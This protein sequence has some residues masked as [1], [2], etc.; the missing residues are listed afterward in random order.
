M[1]IIPRFGYRVDLGFK[2]ERGVRRATL[3]DA[4]FVARE[5]GVVAI[6]DGMGGPGHGELAAQAAL[7]EVDKAMRAETTLGLAE[8]YLQHPDL[9]SRRLVLRRLTRIV[10]RAH[11]RVRELGQSF[12]T[13]QEIGTTV[14]VLWLLREEAFLAHVGDGRAYAI[15]PTAVM[16]LTEDHSVPCEV[17]RAPDPA[18]TRGFALSRLGNAV[19]IGERCSVDTLL[20]DLSQ[21]DKLLLLTDGVWNTV[22]DEAELKALLGGKSAGEAAEALVRHAQKSSF[23]DCTAMVVQIGERFVGHKT[24][25]TGAISRDIEPLAESA[26]LVGLPWPRILQ[27]LQIAVHVEFE[28]GQMLSSRVANDR[29]CY[30]ILAGVVRDRHAKC[31][32]QGA[33]LYAESLVGC[34]S[35]GPTCQCVEAARALRIRRDD[36]R[37]VCAADPTLALEL[38]QRLAAHLGGMLTQ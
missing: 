30:I 22:G 28:A 9:E 36:Y 29:V 7:A 32:G 18:R 34:E 10:E 19:G 2:S 11:L 12:P 15:R 35:A 31:R 21:G 5:L 37:E 24:R 26:L 27:L 33:T 1:D 6:A 3:Q 17:Q 14:D 4:T 25:D 38:Y 20:L 16:Q 8:R 13:P 23:D